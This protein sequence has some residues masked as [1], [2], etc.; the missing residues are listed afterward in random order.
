MLNWLVLF[1]YLQ[2]TSKLCFSF[3]LDTILC[4]MW[5]YS[6]F[7]IELSYTAWRNKLCA[8]FFHFCINDVLYLVLLIMWQP[9]CYHAMIMFS[10]GHITGNFVCLD[11]CYA[12]FFLVIYIWCVPFVRAYE[13]NNTSWVLELELFRSKLH[14]GQLVFIAKKRNLHY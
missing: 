3:I 2:S 11:Y 5:E 9:R 1:P 7:E 8:Y 12:W 10:F 14:S 13:I 4:I 6:I